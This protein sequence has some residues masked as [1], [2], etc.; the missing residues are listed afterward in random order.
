MDSKK[1]PIVLL[2]GL[3]HTRR[4]WWGVSNELM[5]AGY[6][7]IAPTLIG[8]DKRH[9]SSLGEVLETVI[10]DIKLTATDKIYLVGHSFGGA[11]A[12][13]LAG[14]IAQNLVSVTYISA[15]VPK[16]AASFLETIPPHFANNVQ[17]F[18][19]QG[20]NRLPYLLW[21]RQ[22]VNNHKDARLLYRQTVVV[23]DSLLTARFSATA[24]HNVPSCYIS[25]AADKSLPADYWCSIQN[26]VN[27][28]RTIAI[29]GAHEAPLLAPRLVADAIQQSFY[30][31]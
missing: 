18:S 7:V 21:Q 11:I 9:P 30:G 6:T 13:H 31:F 5:R 25:L 17:R 26:R 3:W 24:P 14:Q 15:I 2:H 29:P 28:T 27:A 19:K 23:S 8:C 22:F 10:R 12:Y 1:I 16:N 20:N 4:V